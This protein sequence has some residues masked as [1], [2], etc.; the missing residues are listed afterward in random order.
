[1]KN[2]ILLC[3][4]FIALF[5]IQN[6]YAQSSDC[7]YGGTGITVGTTC[8][9]AAFNSTNNTDYWN[10]A[11]GC[12]ATD[13]DDAWWWFTAT[14][15][16]TTI[17]Y[18]STDDAILHLFSGACASNMVA[19]TCSDN[20][21]SGDETIVYATT[22]GTN[23]AIRIQRKA[24]DS[25]MNG[26]IC[27]YSSLA[28]DL[29][30][31]ASTVT[32]GNNYNGTTVNATNTG[33]G[34]L[35]ACGTAPGAP[36]VWY[37]FVGDGSV[38]TASLC[39]AGT[40][41]TKINVY[42][43]TACNNITSCIASN[44]DG[45]GT[46]STVTFSTNVGT[47]Y[48]ILV[49][50]YSN[51]TGTFTL[52][53]TCCTPGI[54]A[55]ATLNS[56]NNG[57]VNVANC[58]NLS[59]TAPPGAGCTTVD[60]YDVYFGTTN[61]PPLYANTTSTTYPITGSPST[62]YYWQIRPKNSSGSAA[63]CTIRSFTTSNAGN[64]EYTLVDDATSSSPYDCVT[65]TTT[66]NDQRGCAWD[67]NS[68]L[69]FTSDFSY[70]F[71]IN[72]GTSDGGADGLTFVI[73]NDPLGR[74][75]CG[76]TGEALGAG[77]ISNS[78]VIE[79][80]TYINTNDR[81]DFNTNFIG[82]GGAEDPDHL[83]IWF[84]GNINPDLD[85]NCD[86]TGGGER[87]ATP[88][89]VR[90]KNG[91]ANYNIENGSDHILRISWASGTSTLTAKVMNTAL[92]TTY[93]TISTSLNPITQFGTNIP[94]FG[95]TASTGGLNN[96]QSFCN[97]AVLLPVELISFHSYCYDTNKKVYWTTAS[98]NN[99]DYFLL[100]KSLDGIHFDEVIR[101]KS[102]Q[103]WIGEKSYEFVDF[104]NYN[105]FVYY[106]LIQVD[107]DGKRKT[108]DVISSSC[109][110]NL[111][112]NLAIRSVNEFEESIEFILEL[113]KASTHQIS[114]IDVTGNSIIQETLLGDNLIHSFS[115]KKE[116]LAKSLY[117]IQLANEDQVINRKF[118]VGK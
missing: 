76:T 6:Y 104:E 3:F 72:L 102:E 81:D 63:G 44:D 18:N 4:L 21:T 109:S 12:S 94:F 54:P 82:C 53:V 40:Y 27:V 28:N 91:A 107:L 15:T 95:F 46:Q 57:A 34:A 99:H 38:V 69:N 77:G 97:P 118:L 115:I 79:V 55:C 11:A 64:P 111:K 45:C 8:T 52:S 114:I 80:D 108:F 43:G 31:N 41:D 85:G 47:K 9:T 78:V 2:K 1:M 17:T 5:L 61:P 116:N 93:G 59:W 88:T 83:D 14:A 56:P 58:S 39:T 84:N 89:A 36:G 87:P 112:N 51:A 48:Y 16:S 24:S 29:I 70:D 30:C 110:K 92:T 105:D 19:L 60:S 33:E 7:S 65:L 68:N 66:S 113:K 73:Q 71:R 86:A 22:I 42:G 26:T 32:C 35:P 75:K 23:Y 103:K 20:S 106:R 25:N 74:C 62:V 50:G 100:E 101:Y 67:I 90:L 117:F 10:S 49:N 37:V 13:N 96:N 98:E